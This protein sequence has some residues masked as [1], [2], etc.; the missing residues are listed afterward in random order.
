MGPEQDLLL[1]FWLPLAA[2]PLAISLMI[3]KDSTRR[4]AGRILGMALLAAL[5]LQPVA[6]NST[7]EGWAIHLLLSILGPTLLAGVGCL[8]ALFS[9]PIPVA[10]LPRGLRPV[11]FVMILGS[12]IWFMFMLFESRPFLGGLENPWW[13]HLVTS[14][15]TTAVICSGFAAAFA[16]V[17]GDHRANEGALMGTMS[18]SAFVLLIYLLAQG[19]TSDD[20]VFWRAASWGALG[21]LAGLLVG[22][23]AALGVFIMLVWLGERNQP[24]PGPVEPLSDE[25]RERISEILERHVPEEVEE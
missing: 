15:L 4:W 3:A 13:Q 18:I 1:H 25:E 12:I 14:L 20:P 21:D 19:T 9:G 16:L 22:G 17:M 7:G 2:S 5:L 6:L 10:P 11:G 24:V 8:I 23:L